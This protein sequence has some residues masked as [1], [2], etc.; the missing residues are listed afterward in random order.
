MNFWRPKNE[1]D[2]TNAA[3]SCVTV[4]TGLAAMI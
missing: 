4:R 2:F 1:H 3:K